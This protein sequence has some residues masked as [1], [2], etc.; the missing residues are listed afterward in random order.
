MN[1]L[2]QDGGW[3]RGDFE[4]QFQK[5]FPYDYVEEVENIDS[6][7]GELQKGSVSLG[8]ADIEKGT[9]ETFS[10]IVRIWTN[11]SPLPFKG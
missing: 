9:D 7:F 3:W 2:K 11:G 10:N 1:V 8:K 5:L 6:P 4:D